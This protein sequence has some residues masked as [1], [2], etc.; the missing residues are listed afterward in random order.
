MDGSLLPI[1]QRRGEKILQLPLATV[2][3][4][5][6]RWHVLRKWEKDGSPWWKQPQSAHFPAAT[7][8]PAV[9]TGTVIEEGF[10]IIHEDGSFRK[11][12]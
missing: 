2:G 5:S 3:C 4:F 9:V 11:T 6:I 7:V 8:L 12:M 10:S 1:N